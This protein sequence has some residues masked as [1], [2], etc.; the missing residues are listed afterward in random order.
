MVLWRNFLEI[1]FELFGELSRGG[2]KGTP[3]RDIV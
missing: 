2:L 3:M 1:S